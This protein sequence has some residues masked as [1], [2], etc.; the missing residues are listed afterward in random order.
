MTKEQKAIN[1]K[2]YRLTHKEFL[3]K[4]GKVYYQKNKARIRE[5]LNKNYYKDR[6]HR[7]Q[8]SREYD[9][10]P[11]IRIKKNEQERVRRAQRRFTVLSH[12][13]GG[14]PKCAK[15]GFSDIRAL[16]LDH[17]NNDGYKHR[18]KVGR[19][20]KDGCPSC[21]MY[22]WIIRNNFPPIFQVLC[23]N[24]NIIKERERNA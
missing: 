13:S 6:E 3:S 18:R 15:C 12:Y 7:L 4:K 22:V 23:F 11:E 2:N 17:I 19:G 24:C 14:E 1:D 8:Q 9:N 10:R 16:A 20:D 21:M 5:R